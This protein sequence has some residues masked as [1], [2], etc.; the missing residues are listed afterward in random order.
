MDFK[1]GDFVGYYEA[2]KD[3]SG[4]GIVLGREPGD[5]GKLDYTPEGFK[6]WVQ[7]VDTKVYLRA[8]FDDRV[9]VIRAAAPVTQVT[10]PLFPEGGAW[11][12][13]N[14]TPLEDLAKL[15][16]MVAA[17]PVN[18]KAAFG[19][20]KPDLALIPPVSEC[21]EAMAF[22]DGARRYGPFN[23][24][25]HPVEAMTYVA[26]IKRHLGLWLDGQEYTADTNVH[27]LGAIKASCSILLDCIELGTLIDNR[28]PP[29]AAEAV[30]TRLKAQKV[31]EAAAR[32]GK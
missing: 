21:H 29:G 13:P 31:R 22:E 27:N 12:Q 32:S 19:A 4:S 25:T 28:P 11:S 14:S 23:W 2:S 16:E 30:Q 8:D 10:L 26:A 18:P 6:F 24:R 7:N 15:V 20:A 3:E 1:I 17:P 5:I 9:T